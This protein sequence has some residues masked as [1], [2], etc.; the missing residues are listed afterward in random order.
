MKMNKQTQDALLK[1]GGAVGTAFLGAISLFLSRI[2]EPLI[3]WISFT[4]MKLTI[5]WTK[6]KTLRSLYGDLKK[7]YDEAKGK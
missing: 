3:A 7:G 1:L 5:K 2:L 6:S 4:S